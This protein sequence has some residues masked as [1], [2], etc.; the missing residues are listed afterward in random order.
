MKCQVCGM[1]MPAVKLRS[2]IEIA[3]LLP[4]NFSVPCPMCRVCVKFLPYHF[5][6]AHKEVN[7]KRDLF[8]CRAC[9]RYFLSRQE[10][11]AHIAGHE[12]Y[13]CQLCGDAFSEFTE[14]GWHCLEEHRKVFNLGTRSRSRRNLVYLNP[15][16]STL[17]D[18]KASDKEPESDNVE[19]Y[20]LENG[21]EGVGLE[22]E[23]PNATVIED[24]HGSETITQP[25][26]LPSYVIKDTYDK[27]FLDAVH[28]SNDITMAGDI[29]AKDPPP[30]HNAVIKFYKI[31]Q[32]N[33]EEFGTLRPELTSRNLLPTNEQFENVR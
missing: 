4:P 10:L 29:A 3:H 8:P 31:S 14:L 32:D 18:V 26:S 1:S 5:N 33:T 30:E 16:K 27:P 12:R 21:G 11:D 19:I 17:Y 7:V 2:H 22:V 24:L 25:S 20:V 9:R 13:P 23:N 6:K 28:L 15:G